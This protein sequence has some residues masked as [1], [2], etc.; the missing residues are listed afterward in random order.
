[1]PSWVVELTA[2]ALGDAELAR[3]LRTGTPAAMARVREGRV[4]LDVRTVLPDQ[5]GG[6]VEAVRGRWGQGPSKTSVRCRIAFRR[7]GCPTVIAGSCPESPPNNSW[8]VEVPV[9]TN[10]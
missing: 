10:Q 1:M 9:E 4:V 3:R 6:L 7:A 5:E 2:E 8:V